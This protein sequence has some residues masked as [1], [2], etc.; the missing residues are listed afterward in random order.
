MAEATDTAS[1]RLE[2]VEEVSLNALGGEDAGEES[3]A[4]GDGPEATDSAGDRIGEFAYA[5]LEDPKD[6]ALVR[7][8]SGVE[9]SAAMCHFGGP[10]GLNDS[11]PPPLPPTVL[12]HFGGGL[13]IGDALPARSAVALGMPD[14]DHVF[15]NGVAL[16]GDSGSGVISS[17]GG[18]VGVLVT[19]GVHTGSIGSVGVDAGLVGITRLGPQVDRAE[20]VLGTSLGLQT[21]A[22]Q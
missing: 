8:D 11:S 20:Q 16:P 14:P 3:W 21:A 6:F 18:A 12:N 19:V 13:L 10:T 5:I 9:A 1:A 17:D 7:L 4:P 2:S 15:A 22:L